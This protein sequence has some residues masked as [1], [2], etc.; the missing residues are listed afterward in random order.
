MQV[1]SLKPTFTSCERHLTT[2]T[3]ETAVYSSLGSQH[4]PSFRFMMSSHSSVPSLIP[5][6]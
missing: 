4:Q 5:L 1:I 2:L 3:H 6:S